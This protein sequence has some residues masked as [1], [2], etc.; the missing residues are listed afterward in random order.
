MFAER[1][2]GQHSFES[3]AEKLARNF[4]GR[5]TPEVVSV[6]VVLTPEEAAYG[7]LVT[8]RIPVREECRMCEGTGIDW[9]FPCLYCSGGG[10][11]ETMRSVQV[12]LPQG[13]EV[14]ATPEI[15]L[16]RLGIDASIRLRIHL[17]SEDYRQRP[18]SYR[19][20]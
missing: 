2:A 18:R 3:W 9:P 12:R 14:G 4:G 1:R 13:L 6:D 20:F 11:V 8:L 17:S 7:C 10:R 19:G 5:T 15:S 16:Q